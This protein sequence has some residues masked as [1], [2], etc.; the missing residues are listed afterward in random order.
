MIARLALAVIPLLAF[1]ACRTESHEFCAAH[2]GV[3]GCPVGDGAGAAVTCANDT[4]CM[5][6][7]PDHPAC[8]RAMSGGICVVCTA[9]NATAC[10]NEA[11]VCAADDTC[12]ACASDNECVSGV[13]L[14]TGACAPAG[15]VLHVAANGTGGPPCSATAPCKIDDALAQLGATL[16]VIKLEDA[17]PFTLQTPDVTVASLTIDARSHAIVQPKNGGRAV[18]SVAGGK[19]LTI[20]GGIIAGATGNGG[21]GIKCDTSTL[22]L[23]G[24]T[25]QDNTESAID[26][27]N[28][29]TTVLDATLQNNDLLGATNLV[30][31]VRS[32]G[33]SLTLARS[34][35]TGNLGGGISIS[36]ARFAIVGNIIMKNGTDGLSSFGGL[37]ISNGKPGSRLEFNSIVQNKAQPSPAAGVQCTADPSFRAQNNIIWNNNSQVINNGGVQ[38]VPGCTHAH[39]DIGPGGT[40]GD[41]N[42]NLTPALVSETANAHLTPTSQVRGMAVVT[43]PLDPLSATDIDGQARVAPFDLGADQYYP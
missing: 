7:D 2:P 36:D 34:Y 4:D 43:P 8:D 22:D 30:A 12:R 29:T 13:C 26:A 17:G 23:Y 6:K 18:L 11:P 16:N 3:D 42:V 19:S 31:G 20:L 24:T 41:T 39:S 37:A 9:S 35:V 1:A 21:D 32:N 15:S 14:P 28:C 5:T 10:T 25:V 40:P 38:V 27:N 33:G